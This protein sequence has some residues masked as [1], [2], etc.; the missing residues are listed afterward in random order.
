[1]STPVKSNIA[2]VPPAPKIETVGLQSSSIPDISVSSSMT[3][4]ANQPADPLTQVIPSSTTTLPAASAASDTLPPWLKNA[5]EFNPN[6]A[7]DSTSSTPVDPLLSAPATQVVSMPEPSISTPPPEIPDWLKSISAPSVTENITSSSD[8][9]ES[10]K[11]VTTIK[12][13]TLSPASSLETPSSELPSWLMGTSD[14]PSSSNLPQ[15]EVVEDTIVSPDATDISV[16]HPEESQPEA[17]VATSEMPSWLQPSET[18]SES[19]SLIE[20]SS[21]Q[22]T[23]SFSLSPMDVSLGETSSVLGDSQI[24][25]DQKV[26]EDV[27][28]SSPEITET[29]TTDAK[30]RKPRRKSKVQLQEEQQDSSSGFSANASDQTLP[31]TASPTANASVPNS[32][33]PEWLR[34]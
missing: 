19:E 9:I 4:D 2:P 22:E 3:T 18:T 7:Q 30:P 11:E 26:S 6:Q 16:D 1:M 10:G 5:V 33:L 13:P 15:V 25:S 29:T 14:V 28:A 8:T 31:D 20:K 23:S 21:D 12:E 17:S 27:V 34:S 32:D 24:S